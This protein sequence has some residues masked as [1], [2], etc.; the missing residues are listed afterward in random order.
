MPRRRSWRCSVGGCSGF[1]MCSRTRMPG[2]LAQRLGCRSWHRSGRRCWCWIGWPCWARVGQS[3]ASL[4]WCGQLGSRSS[5]QAA[6]HAPTPR[7]VALS[8]GRP[9][10]RSAKPRTMR[11]ALGCTSR[12]STSAVGP[13]RSP[14]GSSSSTT[15]TCTTLCG[16]GPS[17]L[18]RATRRC[19]TCRGGADFSGP[20]KGA[21]STKWA[22][23][24]ALGARSTQGRCSAAHGTH[25]SHWRG[26]SRIG[27]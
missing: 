25:R 21:C 10:G 4:A 11:R 17:I 1:G 23:W 27:C 15:W 19:Q 13:R 6:S 3:L 12:K 7:G 5:C 18:T 16:S 8:S 20:R 26:W 22:P 9:S 24:L 2:W 14:G